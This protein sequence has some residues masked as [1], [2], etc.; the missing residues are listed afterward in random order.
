M[1]KEEIVIN[2]LK[3]KKKKPQK[4]GKGQRMMDRCDVGEGGP[5][6]PAEK[7]RAERREL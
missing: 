3:K 1:S 7:E 2:T 4:A 5:G 6:I